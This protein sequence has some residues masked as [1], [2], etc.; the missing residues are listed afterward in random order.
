M[1]DHSDFLRH[2]QECADDIRACIGAAV[3]DPHRRQDVFQ[4]VSRVLWRR[5]ED[6]DP[7]WSFGAWARG[8]AVNKI[9]ESH[10][11]DARFPLAL[12]P[13][14]L[15]SLLD[16]FRDVPP[17]AADEEDALELCLRALPEHSR[18]LLRWRYEDGESC[19]EL[20]RRSSVNPKAMHQTLSRLRRALA[21]CI[22]ERLSRSSPHTTHA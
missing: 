17:P 19:Q 11:D 4:E 10:R 2:F 15:V 6:Y 13:E 20:A 8:I 9:I 22:R 21:Q 3:R 16:T 14:V 12:P 7:A 18:R 5:F 1:P